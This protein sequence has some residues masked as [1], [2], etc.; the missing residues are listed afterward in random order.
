MFT[1]IYVFVFVFPVKF[2]TRK[3][4]KDILTNISHQSRSVN[5]CKNTIIFLM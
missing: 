4:S 5:K 1:R 3:V 2:V